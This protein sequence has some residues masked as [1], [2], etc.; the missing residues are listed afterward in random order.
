MISHKC[1]CCHS[2]VNHSSPF[3]YLGEGWDI[4]RTFIL[5]V[6][7]LFPLMSGI[8]S[9]IM[10]GPA[11]NEPATALTHKPDV[12]TVAMRLDH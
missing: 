9:V 2:R 1:D 12:T 8:A 11:V 7:L 4:M 6:V 10:A 3:Q 5:V